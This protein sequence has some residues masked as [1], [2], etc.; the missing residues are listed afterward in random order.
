MLSFFIWMIVQLYCG[1]GFVVVGFQGLAHM[2]ASPAEYLIGCAFV[3]FG[4]F[5]LILGATNGIQCY[6]IYIH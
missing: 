1:M 3:F 4:V 2:W 5:L 6:E